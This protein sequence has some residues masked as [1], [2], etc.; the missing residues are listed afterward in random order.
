MAFC[1]SCGASITPGTRF[2]NK[3]G[4]AILA[5][6]PAPA[7]APPVVAGSAPPL[8][9]APATPAPP[10]GGG[11]L[12]AILIVVGVVVLVGILGVASLGFFAWRVARHTRVRQNGD[13][14]RVE[15]PFGTVQTTNDPQAAARDLGVDP[16][17]GA[18]VLKEGATSA[19]FGAVHTVSLNFETSDSVD[20]VCNFYTP[21]FPNAM[22]MTT[23]PNQC[24]IVSNDQ[25]NMITITVKGENDKTRIVI[26]NMSK[27][28]AA[29]SSSN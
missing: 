25:K 27:S 23:D 4:A 6:S 24:T 13:N 9:P 15:T 11:A 3:C 7:V 20:K 22:V 5:S 19:T 2:C 12:K 26:T 29:S 17:P 1:N 18:Q 14:V 8:T 16:Y 28:G 21:K 10:S